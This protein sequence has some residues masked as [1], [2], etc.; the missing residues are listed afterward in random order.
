MPA[1]DHNTASSATLGDSEL[2]GVQRIPFFRM[3][4]MTDEFENMQQLEEREEDRHQKEREV[5]FENETLVIKIL[6][7]VSG[8]AMIG[9]LS[10]T[11]VLIDLAGLFSFL[12]FLTAM[13]LALVAAVFTA[14]WKHQYKMWDI[15]GHAA[16]DEQERAR[17]F[18]L[19]SR[20]L[21]A[22]RAA[23]RASL[24]LITTGFLQLIVFLWIVAPEGQSTADTERVEALAPVTYSIG[25][26]I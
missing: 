16:K 6:Q 12:V 18:K 10:Q 13:G 22:M 14:H 5:L 7:T 26:A 23:M 21:V 2:Y 11:D 8:A 15:K 17:R 4:F 19:S 25:K 20:Y 24:L 9:G 1:L 3:N